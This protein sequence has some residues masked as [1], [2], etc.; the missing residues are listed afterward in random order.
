[1]TEIISM[2]LD[3]KTLQNL[4]S[5]QKELGSTGRSETIRQCIR[6]FA[7]EKKQFQKMSGE[8]NGVVLVVH[9]DDHSETITDIRHHYQAI[10]KTQLH[11]HLENH[12]CLE[13]FMVQGLGETVKKFVSALQTSK[14]T[15][16]V[17]L[18][19]V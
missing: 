17:K 9:P 4:D 2:S 10:I 16:L 1:M 5:L 15:D 19:V 13:L 12:V 8:V 18:I 6:M 3:E 11:N 14:K 7:N